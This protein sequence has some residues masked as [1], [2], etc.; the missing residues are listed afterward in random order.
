[1]RSENKT[2]IGKS[3][4]V[5]LDRADVQL[6]FVSFS[7]FLLFFQCNSDSNPSKKFVLEQTLNGVNRLNP[8]LVM[9]L[10]VNLDEDENAESINLVRNGMEE[11][12]SVFKSDKDGKWKLDWKKSFSLVNPGAFHYSSKERKWL[13]EKNPDTKEGYIIKKLLPV[14][15][16]GDSFHSLF[17]E[18]LFEDPLS[19][20]YSIPVGYRKG[21]K[22]LD[23]L[24][25]LAD[26][27][28]LK[29]RNR[30]DFIYKPEDKSIL[31]FPEERNLSIE[32]VF[33][34]YE[35]IPNLGSRPIPSITKISKEENRYRI[36][37]KN[38][39]GV[40]SVTYL[41]LS[42]PKGGNLK[43]ASSNG[44]RVYKP[45]D[46]VFSRT[47]G[48]YIPAS[49]PMIEVTRESWGSNYRFSFEFEYEGPGDF[50]LYRASYKYNKTI[51]TIPDSYSV[52][53]VEV[54]QQGFLSYRLNLP[55]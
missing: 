32:F 34:G 24:S 48:K 18:I 42:F 8:E 28:V 12:I 41:T 10:Q 20:L 21:I 54:D 40:S 45:G 33:N 35:M 53:P 43:A 7:I 22:I 11:Y 5:L 9:S 44:L 1:L 26:H 30:A 6:L 3:S 2:L 23:G 4:I 14:L 29:A 13:P 51:E 46:S 19:D 17:L 50:I 31:V 39:G 36:E 47:L 52:V 49:Y 27:P 25:A 15:L 37:C 38:R 16:P 55:R